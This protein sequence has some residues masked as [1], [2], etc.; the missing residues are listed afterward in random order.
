LLHWHGDHG[1]PRKNLVKNLDE[2][3]NF[4]ESAPEIYNRDIQ[5]NSFNADGFTE[6]MD[7]IYLCG[8]TKL[9]LMRIYQP[10]RLNNE[11]YAVLQKQ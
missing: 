10:V 11:F 7:N 9:K 5:I 6:L 3:L 2:V 4:T 1:N 8:L